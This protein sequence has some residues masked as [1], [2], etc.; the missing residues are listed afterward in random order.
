MRHLP[1]RPTAA[2]ALVA[3][4]LMG[5]AGGC[6]RHEGSGTGPGHRK[7]RLGLTPEQEIALGKQAYKEIL[8]KAAKGTL[9]ASGPLVER[10]RRVGL[11][12]AKVALTNKL[13]Q[14]EINLHLQGYRLDMFQFNVIRSK[15]INAF[16]LPGGKVVVYTGL[17]RLTEGH[18]GWLATVLGH[19]IGHALAHHANERITRQAMYQR[20]LEAVGGGLGRLSPGARRFLI[21]LLA[22]GAQVRGLAY[23]RQQESEAD[24]IGLFLMTF[25]GYNPEDAIQFWER[26]EQVSPGGRQPEILSTHPNHG[27]RIKQLRRWVPQAWA[28]YQAY[29]R[30]RV[31][32]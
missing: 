4:V 2:A 6:G 20:A 13:L 7:Q 24:H 12:I 29:Q 23:D 11:R 14:R 19:E 9:V 18:D 31:V 1:Y 10:V 21:G 15:Q 3:L 30:G 17:L 22:G 28:A 26:M 16:C 32:K 25:A 8:D 5:L 27:R